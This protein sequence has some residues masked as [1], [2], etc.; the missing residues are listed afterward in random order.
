MTGP[1]P[2][3]ARGHSAREAQG[4]RRI[5]APTRALSAL[6]RDALRGVL[7]QFQEPSWT[8]PG[9]ITGQSAQRGK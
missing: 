1:Q 8:C 4:G 7:E 5:R 9:I 2:V 6:L 3:G